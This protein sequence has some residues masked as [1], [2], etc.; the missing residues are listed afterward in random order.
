MKI[1]KISDMLA[2]F[3]KSKTGQA[4]YKT[5]LKPDKETFLNNTLP[6]IESAVCTGS[7]IYA[8]AH[9]KK[10]PKEQKP[11]LQWQNVING[12]LGIAVSSRLNKL[13]SKQGAKI[14]KD[15]K[16]E[17]VKDFDSVVNG[18]R[19]GLPILVTSLVMRWGVST[20]SVPL[21][22]VAKKAHETFSGK[23]K[24]KKVELGKRVDVKA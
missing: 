23:M 14:I 2:R 8:T 12:V 3:A 19:V 15:L 11:I 20:A 10:I 5:L 16:P 21:S 9:D 6:L 13:A 22:E 24:E 18:V 4:M 17:L 1:P 7:Y